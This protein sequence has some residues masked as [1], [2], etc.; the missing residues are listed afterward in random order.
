MPTTTSHSQKNIA[1]KI[2][3]AYEKIEHYYALARVMK[4]ELDMSNGKYS[5]HTTAKSLIH[6]LDAD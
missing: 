5:K 6:E 2:S 4:S 3:R 1:T